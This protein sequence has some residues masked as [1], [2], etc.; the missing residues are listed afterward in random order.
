M[1]KYYILFFV[2]I[3]TGCSQSI[4][5]PSP[6]T[7]T[8]PPTPTIN[9]ITLLDNYY[10][11]DAICDQ[12]I[13]GIKSTQ[14][15]TS[16]PNYE[17]EEELIA[18]KEKCDVE[19][20]FDFLTH[21]EM[22]EGYYLDY[23]YFYTDMGGEPIFYTAQDGTEPFLYYR[24]YLSTRQDQD[25]PIYFGWESA[26]KTISYSPIYLENISLD[27]TPEAFFELFMLLRLGTQFHLYWHAAYNDTQIVCNY[28]KLSRMNDFFRIYDIFSEEELE[29]ADRLD[30][31]PYV[32][33]D[34]DFVS[35]RVLEFTDWGGYSEVIYT[36]ERQAPYKL[37]GLEENILI[38]YESNI[39]Y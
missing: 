18:A 13:Y 25:M 8:I 37:I 26:I 11:M 29:Q 10:A 17:N 36:F 20:Y 38:E 32:I 5:E 33:F 21:L 22:E 2:L 28:E 1:K 39:S 14:T 34:E 30:F 23:T 3:L 27:D 6:P 15:C 35:V 12:A 4:S 19:R 31:T 9:P 16:L 7:E 24:D